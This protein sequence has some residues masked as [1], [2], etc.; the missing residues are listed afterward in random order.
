MEFKLASAD[1]G[2]EDDAQWRR[3]VYGSVAPFAMFQNR[4]N[5][6]FALSKISTAALSNVDWCVYG[7]V[8]FFC[9]F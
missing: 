5:S 1:G 8:L 3:I 6:A 4:K 9:L 2:F 7:F